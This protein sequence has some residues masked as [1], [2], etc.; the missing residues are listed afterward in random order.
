M[1]KTQSDLI[2][3]YKLET[4]FLQGWVRHTR[5]VERAGNRNEKIQEDWHDCGELGSGG[6]GRVSREVQEGTD[7]YRAVKT[8]KRTPASRLDYSRELLVMA[9][10]AKVCVLSPSLLPLRDYLVLCCNGRLF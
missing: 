2:S 10:L 9:K 8:I 4:E 3:R 1:D 7:H 6:F 5:I